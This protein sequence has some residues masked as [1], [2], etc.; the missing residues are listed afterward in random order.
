V[1]QSGLR[2]SQGGLTAV[3]K[4]ADGVVGG[5]SFAEGLNDGRT[6]GHG[7][8]EPAMRPNIQVTGFGAAGK[9]EAQTRRSKGPK[10]LR[11]TPQ[12]D[13]P[14]RRETPTVLNPS[15]R[16]IRDPY[17]RWCGRGGVVRLPPIPID[18]LG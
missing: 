11:W 17:V 1:P 3:Q 9:G 4:S 2:S 16:R 8:L 13:S 6:L 7:D 18:P 14:A 5:T 10:P 12:S 15:N